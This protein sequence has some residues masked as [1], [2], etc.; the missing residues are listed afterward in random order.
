MADI[1]LYLDDPKN[2]I[3]SIRIS[4]SESPLAVHI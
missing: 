1:V 2:V 4:D 3:D